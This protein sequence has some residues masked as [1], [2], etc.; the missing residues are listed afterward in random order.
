MTQRRILALRYRED[1]AFDDLARDMYV[2][3]L[4]ELRSERGKLDDV[5][6]D[7]IN[8]YLSKRMPLPELL[9]RISDNLMTCREPDRPRAF[10]L[11]IMAFTKTRQND[12][13]DLVLRTMIPNQ[14]EL[15]NS[16]IISTLTYFRK[17]K[18]L[19]SFDQFLKMLRGEGYP[20]NMNSSALYRREVINGVEITVPPS[21]SSNPVI[22]GTLIAA[23]LRFDQTDRAEAW[24]Q[25]WRATGF[26]DDFSTLC[27][28]LRFYT[29]RKDWENGR[30]TLQ[31]AMTFMLSSTSLPEKRIE[32]LIVHMVHFC[33]TCKQEDVSATLI[34][35]AVRSGFDWRAARRQWDITSDFD[36]AFQRWR[37]ADAESSGEPFQHES[38]A[39]KCY[40]FATL[41]EN[42]IKQACH[43]GQSHPRLQQGIT[44][45]HSEGLLSAMLSSHPQ[46][47]NTVDNGTVPVANAPDAEVTISSVPN[48]SNEELL[49]LKEEI[50]R[51]K[52]MVT[53]LHQSQQV[54][55]KGT[56]AGQ[57]TAQATAHHE[58]FPP[59]HSG[60][61]LMDQVPISRRSS[62]TH[63]GNIKDSASRSH[64][65]EEVPKRM[66]VRTV[67]SGS[68][69]N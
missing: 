47:K 23:A 21:A 7:D 1:E 37:K 9:L 46:R 20:V 17:S 16:L 11:M 6:Q 36:P 59:T 38:V 44:A 18:D 12:L 64:V 8:L 51:L 19:K 45:R 14:F 2:R 13:V 30:H 15:T 39:E 54:F 67:M 42:Q 58:S 41:V 52:T 25:A 4:R 66:V 40:S 50:T 57:A 69:A 33:D 3:E 5:L 32:R 55:P 34:A 28:F 24:M 22:Y 49:V 53:Q 27:S 35:A 63:S 10:Q 31:R 29:I 60:A 56:V 61:P 62:Y 65:R 43:T 68:G 26:M 48:I